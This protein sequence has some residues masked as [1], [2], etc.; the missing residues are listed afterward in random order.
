MHGIIPLSKLHILVTKADQVRLP[1]VP[2]DFKR[3]ILHRTWS[4]QD[5]QKAKALSLLSFAPRFF[6]ALL[7]TAAFFCV[8]AASQ[9]FSQT[10]IDE[11]PGVN[12]PLTAPGN[13]VIRLFEPPQLEPGKEASALVIGAIAA[14][15][16]LDGDTDLSVELADYFA[17]KTDPLLSNPDQRF[18]ALI[19][20]VRDKP[21][22]VPLFARLSQ[23]PDNPPRLRFAWEDEN[24][25]PPKAITF[26]TALN[27]H[28]FTMNIAVRWERLIDAPLELPAE[29]GPIERN[30]VRLD[31]IA[32]PAS[33]YATPVRSDA[34]QVFGTRCQ[35]HTTINLKPV[36][37]VLST[38]DGALLTT[39]DTRSL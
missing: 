31:V 19:D 6:L 5:R 18:L 8:A 4:T 11:P 38:V 25:S 33:A 36:T 32:L 10:R 17:S 3:G 2:V 12:S 27:K 28:C 20:M 37:G 29:I 26:R 21:V 15:F 30:E 1:P 13:R 22:A 24:V 35:S 23:T 16:W 39:I 14:N 9:A 7:I 34:R